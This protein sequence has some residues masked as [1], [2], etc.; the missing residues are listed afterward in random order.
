M[1]GLYTRTGLDKF[2]YPYDQGK[3]SGAWRCLHHFVLG[4]VSL[5][6]QTSFGDPSSM[7]AEVHKLTIAELLDV[8]ELV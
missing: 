6:T 3:A 5:F 7:K 1:Y 4:R 8:F 2:C